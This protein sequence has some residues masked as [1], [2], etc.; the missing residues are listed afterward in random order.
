M[1]RLEQPAATERRHAGS[2]HHA[3]ERRRL[4]GV[5]LDPRRPPASDGVACAAL[6]PFIATLVWNMA[7]S[8]LMSFVIALDVAID[9]DRGRCFTAGWLAGP[10]ALEDRR[11]AAFL[12]DD[13]GRLPPPTDRPEPSDDA[14][15]TSASSSAPATDFDRLRRA[16]ALKRFCRAPAV[17]FCF[18]LAARRCA[19]V[20]SSSEP[21]EPSE[22]SPI[23]EP[24]EPSRS[25]S[26]CLCFGSGSLRRRAIARAAPP[27]PPRAPAS[28]LDRSFCASFCFCSLR[29]A[30]AAAAAPSRPPVPF[31]SAAIAASAMSGPSS[32]AIV[33]VW[34]PAADLRRA[35]A[36][37]PAPV[38]SSSRS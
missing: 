33:T 38:A 24:P 35:R 3:T 21:S 27:A 32:S 34:R 26:K 28:A 6:R 10:A 17:R 12:V 37:P 9:A 15:A 2:P 25:S 5:A 8:T 4:T 20:R 14:A 16:A 30:A 23:D 36:L 22:P 19:G 31:F 13:R 1:R 7:S 11:G 29:T 18:S